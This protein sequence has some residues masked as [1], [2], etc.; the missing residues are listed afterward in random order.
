MRSN[1]GRDTAPEMAL[2]K[3]LFATG[4]RYR[5]NFRPIPNSRMTCDIA[6]PRKRVIVEVRGCFWHGCQ[7]HHRPAKRNADFWSR[8]IAGNVQRD[9]TKAAA[10]TK[11]GWKLV[12]VWEH[13]EVPEAVNRIRAAVANLF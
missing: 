7:Q 3:A 4:L 5:V 11:A 10:L 9:E 1:R 8:K 6:F 13:D 12:V 2:R